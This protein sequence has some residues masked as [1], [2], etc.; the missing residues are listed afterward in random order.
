MVLS[1]KTVNE[2]LE[3]ILDVFV[4]NNCVLS[5]ETTSE[6]IEITNFY[7]NAET[8]TR[9]E[10][11]ENIKPKS[12]QYLIVLSDYLA[13]IAI[14]QKNSQYLYAS[15]VLI[16]IED[17]RWDYRESIIRLA[18]IWFTAKEIKIEP[19]KLFNEIASISSVKTAEF[20]NEFIKRPE[21]SKSLNSMGL[22]AQ[23][24]KDKILIVPKPPPWE[25]KTGT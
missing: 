14:N 17:F 16:S 9:T 11:R 24:S 5:E 22:M 13:D 12:R 4:K 23:K 10:I 7:R 25:L 21:K 20:F 15:A 6:L 2:N 19:E 18:V 3:T 8:E 1:I